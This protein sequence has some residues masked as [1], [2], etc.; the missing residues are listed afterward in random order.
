MKT[1]RNHPHRYQLILILFIERLEETEEELVNLKITMET[2]KQRQAGG[3]PNPQSV[4]NGADQIFVAQ[5][6]IPFLQSSSSDVTDRQGNAPLPHPVFTR[7]G[8]LLASEN[9]LEEKQ[10]EWEGEN[11]YYVCA[12]T[13]HTCTCTYHVHV[14][15]SGVARW[16]QKG[17]LLPIFLDIYYS[18]Q[19]SVSDYLAERPPF[20]PNL[21][22]VS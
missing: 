9:Q 19:V 14:L 3:G 4:D 11:F 20:L 22:A 10:I 18:A 5:G 16:L 6:A 15:I 2:D 12:C 1:K 8:T 17:K 7:R 21:V 13:L